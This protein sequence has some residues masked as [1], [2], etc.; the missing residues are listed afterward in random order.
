[1]RVCMLIFNEIIMDGRVLRAAEAV[2][3]VAELTV[4]GINRGKFDIAYEQVRRRFPFQLDWVETINKQHSKGKLNYPIRYAGVAARMFI[5]AMKL[6]PHVI[7]AHEA[8]MLPIAM[9]IRACNRAAVVY[10][11]HELYRDTMGVDTSPGARFFVRVETWAM[12]KCQAIIA[13][14]GYR[15]EIMQREYGAPFLPTV[16][17]NLPAWQEYRQSRWLRDYVAERNSSIRWIC[18]HQGRMNF[19]R[20]IETVLDCL[21]YLRNDVGIVFVGGGDADYVDSLRQRVREQGHERRVF[22]HPPVNHTE[23]HEVTCSADVGIVIYQNICRNN[24]F[25]A[26]NK[27]YEYAAAGLPMVGADLPSI[28]EF[29]QKT[30]CGILFDPTDGRSLAEAIND[31]LGDTERFAQRRANCLEAAK[32]HCWEHERQRLIELY[33]GLMS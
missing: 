10:D 16:V 5:K 6:R 2:S 23:L 18:L 19:G 22:F 14:N 20:G 11:A 17:R 28:R 3:E 15:A 30:D 24:Y 12:R 31:V 26:P 1:M 7:H 25:C 32:E 13:C 9:A 8:S 33:H 4:I 29:L 21:P 27:M